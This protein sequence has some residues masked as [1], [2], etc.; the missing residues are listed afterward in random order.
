MKKNAITLLA[1]LCIALGGCGLTEPPSETS[2]TVDEALERMKEQNRDAAR[3]RGEFAESE[4]HEYAV[5]YLTDLLTEIF[6]ER[7]ISR[8]EVLVEYDVPSDEMLAA[9]NGDTDRAFELLLTANFKIGIYH[10]E[11]EPELTEDDRDRI[12]EALSERRFTARLVFD[13]FYTWNT[14]TDGEINIEPIPAF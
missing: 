4:L 6:P 2:V 11:D 3:R 5:G 8:F 13:E 1:A 12:M 9:L 14:L 10:S 7:D